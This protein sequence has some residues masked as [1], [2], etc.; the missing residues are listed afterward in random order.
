MSKKESLKMKKKISLL[1]PFASVLLFINLTIILTAFYSKVFNKPVY[2]DSEFRSYFSEFVQDGSKYGV[3]VD[4]YRLITIFSNTY[5]I[6][7]LAYCIPSLNLVVVSRDHW[8]NMDDRTRKILLYHEWGHCIL[9]RQ[10]VE[11]IYNFPTYCPM[12]IMYP[13]IEPP[14]R[15]YNKDT[16]DSYNMELFTNPFNFKKIPAGEF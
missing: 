16:E 6:S 2:L 14:K 8:D 15:C 1:P 11:S 12:S 9:K 7:R 3:K 4:S 5:S 13:Y 10:H